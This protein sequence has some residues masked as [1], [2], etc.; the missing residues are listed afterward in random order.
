[1]PDL[2]GTYFFADYCNP[3]VRT[4]RMVDGTATALR[5][6][7]LEFRLGAAPFSIRE[8]SSFGT[9]G[10]GEVYVC[11]LAGELYR[12]VPMGPNEPPNARV[13]TDPASANL[14]FGVGA[15]SIILDASGSD[16]GD[17]ETETL[18]FRWSKLSGPTGGD[19]IDGRSQAVATVRFFEPGDY[20][21]ELTLSDGLH[22]VTTEVTIAVTAPL[23]VRGEANGDGD[24]DVSDGVFILTRLFVDATLAVLCDDA[25]DT[26]DDG[27]I[28]L[29]DG[30]FLLSHQFLGGAQPPTPYPDCGF[31]PTFDVVGC[32][33]STC[34]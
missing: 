34:E 2:A 3:W 24:L 4:F 20:T 1:M 25:L 17:G 14:R 10:S 23:F 16:D 8:I 22:T 15:R 33:A 19:E 12:V 29:T 6:V 26:N 13:V 32:E 11:D 5:E 9:D 30:V 27:Q 28:D 31:D 7:T 21:Y 18:T